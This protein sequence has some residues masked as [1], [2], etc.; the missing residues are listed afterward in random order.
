MQRREF[1]KA[2]GTVLAATTLPTASSLALAPESQTRSVLFINRNWRFHPAKVEGAHLPEFNDAKFE[3]VV[4]PHTNVSLPWHNFDDHDYEFI[5]TYR[6]RFKY[7]AA[8]KGKRVFVDFEG[9]MTASTVY[10]NG[11]K[12]GEYRGGYTR[13]DKSWSG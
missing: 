13:Y 11:H 5:S 8:A 4:I 12:L 1:I 3:S 2:S 10:C 9:V 7:P 6:R